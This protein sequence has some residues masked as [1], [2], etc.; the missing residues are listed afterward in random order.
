MP[1][2]LSSTCKVTKIKH[3]EVVPDMN[4]NSF[5]KKNTKGKETVDAEIQGKR[6]EVSRETKCSKEEEAG[7]EEDNEE[8]EK[9]ESFLV[10]CCP[11]HSRLPAHV[12][13]QPRILEL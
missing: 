1:V 8:E 6:N 13:Q 10:L 5:D 2:S 11:P 9:I 12:A 4:Q 3:Q 7:E